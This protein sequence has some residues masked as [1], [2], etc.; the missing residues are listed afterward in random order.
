MT[1]RTVILDTSVLVAIVDARDAQHERAGRLLRAL[2]SHQT[3]QIILDCVAVETV[4]VLCRRREERKR[5]QKLPAL[6][7]IFA[8]EITR[9]YPLLDTLW[10]DLLG[11][12]EESDGRINV[13]DALILRY[14]EKYD[15]AAIATF[16]ADF[17]HELGS[18]C[19]ATPPDVEA[20]FAEDG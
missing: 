3:G 16:D 17:K 10:R 8:G 19:L 18:R 1:A 13:H 4:G 12:V 15:V 9:A 7:S 2:E 5:A 20:L 6:S 11:D 14:R